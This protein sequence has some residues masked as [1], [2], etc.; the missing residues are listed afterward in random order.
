MAWTLL[1]TDPK[2][3][4][5]GILIEIHPELEDLPASMLSDFYAR[6]F[7]QHMYAGLVFTQTTTY[8]V[9]DLVTSV[10]F[11][12]NRFDVKPL[13]TAV[14]FDRAG[15]GRP[16]RDAH[17]FL[18]QVREWLEAVDISWYRA[19]PDEA[20]RIMVPNVVGNIMGAEIELRDGVLELRHAVA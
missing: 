12:E 1:G 14:L 4:A 20:V 17:R 13:D 3:R 11:K 2:S 15:V 6:L 16:A 8:V 10:G 9:R 18:G 7:D 19:L 5:S